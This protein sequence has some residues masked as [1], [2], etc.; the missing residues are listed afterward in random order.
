MN[1]RGQPGL[2]T[3]GSGI[4]LRA[5][6]LPPAKTASRAAPRRSRK[7]YAI[8][9]IRSEIPQSTSNPLFTRI[10]V[11]RDRLR[12]RWWPVEM[13][14]VIASSNVNAMVGADGEFGGS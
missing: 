1:G 6:G 7:T 14:S 5:A 10:T 9:L 4:P 8:A 13:H 12:C 2:Q 3:K 11:F